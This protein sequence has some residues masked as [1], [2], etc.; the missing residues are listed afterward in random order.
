MVNGPVTYEVRAFDALG[1]SIAT[2]ITNITVNNLTTNLL[3]N[4]SLEIDANNDGLADCWQRTGYGTNTSIWTRVSGNAHSGNYAESIQVTNLTSGDRKLVP[5]LDS[6]TCAP[7]VTSGARY[8][9][10]GWYKSTTPTAIVVYYRSSTGVW[11]YWKSSTFSAA[12]SSWKQASYTTPPIPTGATTIS[13]G[14]I[15]NDVGT[16]ITDDYAVTQLLDG[17]SS[18]TI[19]PV[20]VNFKPTDGATVSGTVT[21]TA[22]ATDNVAMQRV[23][24]LINDAVVATA[25]SAPYTGSWNS[26]MVVNGP[27]TYAVRAF[28][29]VGNS[30]ATPI[31]NI[32]VNNLTT[33]L[34]TNPSLEIDANND[35]LADCWQ[36]T[37]YGT[38]TFIWTRVSGN[39]HSGNYA[40]SIQVTNLTSGDRKLLPNLDSSACAPAVNVGARYTLSGWYKS[41]LAT[42]IVVF[43]RTSAGAW[44]YWKSSTFS[45]ASSSWKQASYTTPPIPSGA[46][47]ISFGF[48]LSG[49]GTLITDDYSMLI[50]QP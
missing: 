7:T 15:L 34:L 13:F 29:A 14:L 30:T 10:S 12:S 19:P 42:E 9:L 44:Q 41:T 37:G 8:I 26:T 23:E 5:N 16:L 45:A 50:T 20:I 36:R 2:S 17:T 24:F 3:T 11:Q 27:V 43:Y 18:D 28:D 49:V 33:N 25:T 35:G 47:A 46:T 48:A 1:N 21:L 32:T 40:E 38:N 6:S 4:P 39:A 22:D 31:A